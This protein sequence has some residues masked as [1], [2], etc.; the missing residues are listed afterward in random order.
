MAQTPL[1][2]QAPI[3][4]DKL[5][6]L[7]LPTWE[8]VEAL[9]KNPVLR[10][11]RLDIETDSTIRMDEEAEKRARIELISSVSGFL[12]QMVEAGMQAPEIVPMLGEILMFGLRAFKTARAIEQTFDDMMEALNEAAKQPKP[13]DP[14]LL[15]IQVKAQ[16]EQAIASTKARLDAQVAQAQQA[17]QAQ[18]NQQEQQLEAQRDQHKMT[19]DAQ[20]QTHKAQMDAHTQAT[21]QELK[22][23][24]EAQRVQWE[25]AAKE[26]IAALDAQTKL[27]VARLDHEHQAHM[28]QM[29]NTH[30]AALADKT[31]E[32]EKSLSGEK[33]KH[34]EKLAKESPQAKQA[35][36]Q[37]SGARHTQELSQKVADLAEHLK[38]PRK[39]VRDKDG[40][41]ME[42]A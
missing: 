41:I 10:E 14:K 31:R 35:S 11:F 2:G 8:E 30:Q 5:Q 37:E 38:R 36:A 21:I 22:N 29:A 20:L 26:R 39:V 18:Q 3:S 12:T 40:K 27:R 24:F 32:H 28:T 1:P 4:P 13:P 17:A 23:Q 33:L 7:K 34:E 16:T 9:L 19:L 15:E 42:L 25:T 6:L